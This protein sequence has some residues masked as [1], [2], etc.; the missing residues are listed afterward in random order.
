MA[1]A[2]IKSEVEIYKGRLNEKVT[3]AGKLLAQ[4]IPA[5]TKQILKQAS[6]I[7]R[8]LQS[9][10]DSFTESVTRFKTKADGDPDINKI[11][12]LDQAENIKL[13]EH[14]KELIN[15]V[16]EL[17]T[18]A[19]EKDREA[20]SESLKAL[21]LKQK[22]EKQKADDEAK[23][24]QAETTL[25]IED[26]KLKQSKEFDE[27][28]LALEKEKLE[29][30]KKLEESKAAELKE[31]EEKKLA[32]EKERLDYQKKMEENLA[33]QQKEFANRQQAFEHDQTKKT[34]QFA[35]EL[36][37]QKAQNG[38]SSS[39][40]SL[41]AGTSHKT[42]VK[43]PKLEFPK[44]YGEILKWRE[45]WDSFDSAIHSNESLSHIDKLNYLR[46]KLDGPA[47]GVIGGLPLTSDNYKV[48]VELLQQRYGDNSRIVEAHYA[49]LANIQPVSMNFPQLQHLSDEISIHL[50]SLEALGEAVPDGYV[51]N[52]FKSNLPKETISTLEM[53]RGAEKWSLKLFRQ[54]L[55]QYLKAHEQ[56]AVPHSTENQIYK[57]N[58]YQPNSFQTY[59][60]T[61]NLPV[62][63]NPSGGFRPTQQMASS[64]A[65]SSS[66]SN[67]QTRRQQCVYCGGT[68]WSDQCTEY[69]TIEAR[70]ERIKGSCYVCLKQDHNNKNC[71]SPQACFYC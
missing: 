16:E 46:T 63:Y 54:I 57:P 22:E 41:S 5:D 64:N 18:T 36:E 67:Y 24:L 26:D 31:L 59:R 56:E 68:H 6:Q 49:A 10:L 35:H 8:V 28:K 38:G 4:E 11:Y 45:F 66:T 60:P 17:I 27:K 2:E 1:A 70:K 69:A 51:I 39:R 37:L 71:T 48:A 52:L 42:S 40:S 53:H 44:F 29:F 61:H 25:K 23:R 32:I 33:T 20:L 58:L 65:N 21:K 34:N 3:E 55:D 30:Q 13:Q 9:R 50:R 43:L 15:G 19:H 47:L 62:L 14:T 7:K 12:L